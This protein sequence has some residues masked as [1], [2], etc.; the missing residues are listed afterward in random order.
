[1]EY[2]EINHKKYIG[3]TSLTRSKGI[4][5]PVRYAG[6]M[7]FDNGRLIYWNNLSGH[8]RPPIDLSYSNLIPWARRILPENKFKTNFI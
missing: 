1:M 2:H 8:Y 4:A 3:H 5:A 7:K 6:M